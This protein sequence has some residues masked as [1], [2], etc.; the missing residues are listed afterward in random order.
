M[1]DS[2]D[3][4]IVQLLQ[5]DG[6]AS[7][8]EIA[9]RAGVT[10]S[11]AYRRATALLESGSILVT[12]LPATDLYPETARMYEVRVRCRPGTQRAVAHRLAGRSDTRWVAIVTGEYDVAAEVVVPQGE[13]VAAVLLD[14]IQNDPDVVATQTDMVLRSRAVAR[15]WSRG[16]ARDGHEC[17]PSH[18]DSVDRTILA[19]LRDDG[20]RSYA[21]A[22]SALGM[23]ESTVRRRCADVFRRGCAGVVTLVQPHLL[24]YQQEVLIRLDLLPQHVEGA[25]RTLE[26]QEGVHYFATTLGATSLVCELIMKTHDD[27]HAFIRDV[28]T[29][30]PGLTRLTADVELIVFKRGFVVCPWASADPARPSR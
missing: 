5:E 20:R 19:A 7:W 29:P 30:L 16:G 13:D 23:S 21:D 28:V 25:V 2:V 11:T 14:D 9:K 15:D 1:L 24:G 26:G 4:L 17:D 3:L 8:T 22:A 6:R 27:L 10:V 12:V 18:L